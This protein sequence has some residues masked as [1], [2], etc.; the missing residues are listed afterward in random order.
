LPPTVLSCTVAKNGPPTSPVEE[1]SM[2]R[3]PPTIVT[4]PPT[5]SCSITT[6]HA[7][8]AERLPP[9]WSFDSVGQPTSSLH[10]SPAIPSFC[11]VRLPSTLNVPV[12]SVFRNP[13]PRTTTLP[14]TWAVPFAVSV[15]LPA[16]VSDR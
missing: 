2:L 5:C 8:W 9:M 13:C 11:T 15:Q 1:Q 4:L 3:P 6:A 10:P 7:P 16:I 14:L 12:V